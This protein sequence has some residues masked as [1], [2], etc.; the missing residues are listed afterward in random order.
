MFLLSCG[1]TVRVKPTW[2]V[3]FD[4]NNFVR[5]VKLHAAEN[6]VRD[7]GGTFVD[8]VPRANRA[9]TK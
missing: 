3:R 6:E 7:F 8:G 4:R 9:P 1:F 5:N 2:L